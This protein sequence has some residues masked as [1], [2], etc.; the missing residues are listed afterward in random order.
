MTYT[1]GLFNF[2]KSSP[3]AYHTVDTVKAALLLAGYTELSEKSSEGYSDGGKHFVIR[4][5]TSIIAFRGR[6][7]QGGFMICASHGD[8]PSFKVTSGEHGGAYTRLSVEKYGGMIMYSWLDRPLSVAGRVLVRTEDGIASRLVNLDCDSMV[9]PGVAIHMNRGVNDGYKFNPA[10]D[11]IP[12]LGSKSAEGAFTTALA[13]AAGADP[14]GIV[15]HDLFLYNRE[16]GRTVGINGEYILAPRL[17]D[18]GCVYTSLVAFLAAAESDLSVAVLAVFD[19]EEVGSE[20]KQGA[21]ST[22]LDMT[23]RRIAGSEEKYYSMLK[24]SFMVSADNAHAR[25]PNHPEL[26][27][28]H[29]APIL[30]EGVVIKYNANQRY[31]TD[32]VSAALF[33]IMA[34]RSGARLQ[35][36]SNRPDQP[37]GSTLGSIANTR[38]S[39]PTVDIGL[40][41]L[42]MHS[43][44]ETAAA[45]DLTD[46]ISVLREMYSSGLRTDGAN[47]AVVK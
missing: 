9:I 44:M 1:E 39:V 28:S 5:G 14:D 32:G 25:H 17:D 29:Q 10:S 23:L 19:N 11:M 38:V 12:L 34:A 2:I 16:A 30:G 41:Q 33:E 13:E 36:Y 21:N 8:S 47:V 27:D 42:A 43:A 40:P 20:T 18:L 4:N 6:T 31:A 7:E 35:S 3:T 26:S 45:A 37:G 24:D 22:F 15:S 46:M